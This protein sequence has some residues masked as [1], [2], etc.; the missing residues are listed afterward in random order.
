MAGVEKPAHGYLADA[1]SDEPKTQQQAIYTA[2]LG[3]PERIDMSNN[4]AAKIKN[5]LAQLAHNELVS[6]VEAFAK[7]ANLQAITPLLIKGALVAKDP[8]S[9]ETV[10][11]LEEFEKQA[12]RDEVLH[13]WR[14]PKQRRFAAPI[15][16]GLGRVRGT[17][18]V[19]RV[20]NRPF[21]VLY[22]HPLLHRRR[23]SGLGPDR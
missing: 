5:P 19:C 20:L 13:K 23:R 3:Q 16:P 8:A 17:H 21:S 12:I 18:H 14:Q 10:P 7:E 2:E 1:S 11:G 6:D 15:E 9:F 4:L 22:H